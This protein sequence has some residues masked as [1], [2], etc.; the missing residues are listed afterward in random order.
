[1][2]E[3]EKKQKEKEEAWM[4]EVEEQLKKFHVHYFE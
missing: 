4:K 1:M 3:Q 2:T